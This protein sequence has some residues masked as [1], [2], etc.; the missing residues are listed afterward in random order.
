MINIYYKKEDHFAENK[1]EG[2]CPFEIKPTYV[3]ITQEL[4]TWLMIIRQNVY[5]FIFSK[6]LKNIIHQILLMLL[7]K[8]R[9]VNKIKLRLYYIIYSIL[10]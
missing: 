5:C 10:F 6:Y 8:L 1:H 4:K 7:I 9:I 2:I 3:C